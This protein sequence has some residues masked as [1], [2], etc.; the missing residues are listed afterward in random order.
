MLNEQDGHKDIAASPLLSRDRRARLLL[1]EDNPGD[2][3]LIRALLAEADAPNIALEQVSRLSEAA[4][5]LKETAFDAVLLDLNLPDSTGLDTVRRM[6][7]LA[8]ALPI[9]VL[10][11]LD[12][13][14]VGDHAVDAGAHAY[15]VKG[16]HDGRFLRRTLRHAVERQ[17]LLMHLADEVEAR[18]AAHMALE[19]ANSELE[20]RV[21]ERTAELQQVNRALTVLSKCN[22]TLLR[23]REEQELLDA[24]CRL[25]VGPGG[26]SLA[27]VGFA[28]DDATT[29]VRLVA[30]AGDDSDFLATACTTWTADEWD[31]CPAGIAIRTNQT[32]VERNISGN[33]TS[34]AWREWAARYGIQAAIALPLR[35]EGRSIGVLAIYARMPHAFETRELELLDEMAADLSFGIETLRGHAQRL[36]AEER[37]NYLAYHDSLT[38]L[39]NRLLMFERLTQAMAEAGRHARLSALLF[40]DLDRFKNINDS[41]GHEAGDRLLEQ[42]AVRLSSGVRH[43]D[44][45]ARHGGDEF[46]I[47]LANVAQ[48]D[49]IARVTR[50]LLE[51]FRAPFPVA[52]QDLFITSSIGIT[53]YPADGHD[54]ESLFKNADTAL[55]H[56]KESGRNTFQFF[57]AEMNRRVERQLA[58]EMDLR[59]A[60]ERDEFLLYFQPQVDLANGGVIGVEALIRWR[61]GDE[62]IAPAEFIP[63]A[64]DTG[65][66]VPIGEWVLRTAC[67]Q[68]RV[69][70]E[71]GLPPI[72]ISVNLSARQ[73]RDKTL[74]DTVRNILRET[75]AEA[76]WLTLEI[77][78]SA[79]MHDAQLAQAAL[80]ELHAMGV[81]LEVDDFGTGY[82]SL[83]YLK[84]FPIKSLKIDKSFVQD[85]VTEPD[86]AAIAQAIIS[87]AHSLGI[88]VV[89]EGVETK[90]Q[91]AFLRARG[92]D[93]MQG[94]HFSRPIPAEDMARLLAENR[95]LDPP[96]E[97]DAT[98]QQR[99]LLI[100]DDEANVRQA[101]V[102]S[103][104]RDGYKILVASGPLEALE[105]LAQ[106]PVGVILSDQ[107]MP[108]MT[109]V[110][111]LSRVKNLYPNTVRIVLSG[112]TDLESI[113]E[114]IN[115]GA[116]YK[117]LTKPWEDDLLRENLREAF[118]RHAFEIDSAGPGAHRAR[119]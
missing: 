58:L 15:L 32:V 18:R 69:W 95:R 62:M 80:K 104:R 73:F 27:W 86:D 63:L 75:G 12:D 24:L 43:G 38:G 59:Q 22:R 42:V 88:K 112:Y 40:L 51:I 110:E 48:L 106:H 114:A 45:V 109:G 56:A 87:L 111:F 30:K 83:A 101:L 67:T 76:T 10:T 64:E 34:Q 6:L 20:D 52:G 102:R 9:V 44:T 47:V 82:S 23:T 85:I 100:V 93:V 89:A 61:R 84:R 4:Q 74:V 116:V 36:R 26:Y 16:Q 35:A 54:P 57:T 113:T 103:L 79:I 3:A 81:G 2:A 115:R 39:P 117:F 17:R 25:I 72:K 28:E 105:L 108:E 55:H 66:I 19:R 94:Y 21:A 92:C 49:D 50:K 60:L 33:G 31:D 98:V 65:L 8:P 90:P 1:V 46:A 107:R 91:L 41:L 119:V 53:L 97:E 96:T 118:R 37:L 11:G 7:T 78:E 71:A 68:A 77:T 29:P 99:T 70:R 5:R 14:I 13:E